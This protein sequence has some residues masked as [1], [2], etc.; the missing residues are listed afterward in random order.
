MKVD[1]VQIGNSKGIRIP[2]AVLAQCH[3]IKTVDMEI[4]DD[5]IILKSMTKHP[6]FGWGQAFVRMAQSGD[7]K[8]LIDDR[9]DLDWKEW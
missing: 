3:M 5:A 2:K 4:K 6:R 1:I 8:L 9:I 7:D